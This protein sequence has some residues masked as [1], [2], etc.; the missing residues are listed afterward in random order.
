MKNEIVIHHSASRKTTTVKDIELW[1]KL[2]DW[3]GGA[4][5]FK[6]DLGSY[7]QYH[8]IINDTGVHKISNDWEHRWHCG[9]ENSESIGICVCGDYTIE[10]IDYNTKLLLEELLDRLCKEHNIPSNMVK[11][12]K[13]CRGANTACPA[14]LMEFVKSYRGKDN[15]V[16][17]LS[18]LQRAVILIKDL[19]KL[20][21]D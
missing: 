18:L 4:R 2:K 12:H 8:Y 20:K 15:L 17:Q 21:D 16:K 1:H 7:A 5:A 19:I 11:G 6:S 13:E 9:L 3:G 14:S 10:T